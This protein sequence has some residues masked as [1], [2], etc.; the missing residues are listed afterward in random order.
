MINL[1]YNNWQT[2]KQGLKMCFIDFFLQCKPERGPKCYTIKRLYYC[3]RMLNV[4]KQYFK[5][6]RDIVGDIYVK[7]EIYGVVAIELTYH[8]ANITRKDVVH[9]YDKSFGLY[10]IELA[11]VVPF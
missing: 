3:K 4:S 2:Q 11:L 7:L 9:P 10:C 8:F 5:F 6:R 1:I